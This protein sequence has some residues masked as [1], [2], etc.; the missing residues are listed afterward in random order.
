MGNLGT[1]TNGVQKQ[2]QAQAPQEQPQDPGMMQNAAAMAGE[3]QGEGGDIDPKLKR[4][5]EDYTTTLMHVIHSE[6]TNASIV[7][8]LSGGPP[9][10]SIPFTANQVHDMVSQSV[11]KQGGKKISDEVAIAGAVYMV[12]DL[13]ELGS[14]SGAFEQELPPEAM[15][16]ILGMTMQKH[17]QT[18]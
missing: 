15:Q 12:S 17:I 2:A 13:A 1:L 7:E 8:M 4:Q 10:E 16:E 11:K 14:V 5:M 18:I 6:E 3:G 9:M